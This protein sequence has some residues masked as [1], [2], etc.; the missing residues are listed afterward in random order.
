MATNLFYTHQ[1]GQLGP[2]LNNYGRAVASPRPAPH[3]KGMAAEMNLQKAQGDSRLLAHGLDRRS[4]TPEPHLKGSQAQANYDMGQGH[5]VDQLFHQYGRMEQSSRSG[6]KVKYDGV[7]NM[8][9][10]QGDEMRKTLSQ[11]PPTSRHHVERPQS[12]PRWS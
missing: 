8:I 7:Q 11:C 5:H 2:I 6:P 9:K 12:A 10:G 3:V 4:P 1:E